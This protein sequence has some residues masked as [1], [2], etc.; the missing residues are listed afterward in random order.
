MM[1][2]MTD[3]DDVDLLSATQLPCQNRHAQMRW[4]KEKKRQ[5]DQLVHA[6]SS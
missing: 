2:M 4:R 6:V 1:M 3:D 5:S